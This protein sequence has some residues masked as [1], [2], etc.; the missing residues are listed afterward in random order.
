MRTVFSVGSLVWCA[1]ICTVRR[2]LLCEALLVDVAQVD[3]V[4]VLSIL[5][6]PMSHCWLIDWLIDWFALGSSLYGPDEPG[7]TD[8]PF[9]PHNL[10]S[11]QD[12]LSLYQS[13]GRPPDLNLNVLWIQERNPDILPFSLKNSRQANPLQVPQRGPYGERDSLTG[14][15]YTSLD[16]SV[17]LKGPKK[18]AFLKRGAH[19][20]TDAHSRA[21]LNIS[22]GV[23]L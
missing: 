18:R 8:G 14:H 1:A 6:L 15:F 11:S 13:F 2:N 12:S 4:G 19:M 3:L 16:T 23:P 21:L 17:Y 5:I 10:I 7:L 20:D 22:F 9:V